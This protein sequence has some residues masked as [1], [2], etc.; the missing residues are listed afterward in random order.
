[1]TFN[2]VYADDLIC[3]FCNERVTSGV[4]FRLGCLENKNYKPGEK[5]N[6]EGA[7]CR[8]ETHPKGGNIKSVGY[9]NCDNVKCK[10]WTDCFPEVQQALVIV[11]NDVIEKVE[12]YKG[13]LSGEQ[14]EIIEPVQGGKQKTRSPKK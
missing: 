9:F 13:P 1:M 4:G 6:W 3:P 7:I 11:K 14:F 2:T 10:S 12:V 8:P 5:L